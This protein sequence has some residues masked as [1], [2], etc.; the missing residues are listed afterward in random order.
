MSQNKGELE[1]SGREGSK[2]LSFTEHPNKDGS[3]QLTA[4]SVPLN[5]RELRA[6]AT[7]LETKEK[8]LA[9]RYAVEFEEKE[10]E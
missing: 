10:E 9:R 7:L 3:L 2:V 6:A 8:D 4:L 5:A 1:I